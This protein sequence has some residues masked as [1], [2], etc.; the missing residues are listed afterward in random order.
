[1]MKQIKYIIVMLFANLTMAQQ[2]TTAKLS[3]VHIDGLHEI[4]LPNEIRSFSKRNLNDFR[5]LDSYGKEVPFFIRKKNKTTTTN[6]FI[7]FE[8]ISRTVAKDTSSII[9]FKNPYSTLQNMVITVANF[10]GSKTYSL[11]G[12][13]DQKQWFGLVNNNRLSN[14]QDA[15]K[16]SIDKAISF[17]LSSYPY[18]RIVF[19]DKNSQALNVLKIGAISS[20]VVHQDLQEVKIKSKIITEIPDLKKT[21]IHITFENYEI[22]NH[23]LFQIASPELYNRQVRFYKISLRE[24]KH[25]TEQYQENLARFNLNSS[26]NKLFNISEIFENDIYI[27]IDNKDDANLTFNEIEFFQEPLYIIA[28]LKAKENYI[29]KTGD[30]NLD[31]PQYDISYFKNNIADHLPKAE[32]INVVQ[33]QQLSN[34]IDDESFWQKSWFMWLSILLAGI[35][36]LYFT[37]SLVKDIKKD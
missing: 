27:E 18:L 16:T 26:N 3:E 31:A 30:E 5:I 21:Q 12:S 17:P 2:N 36:I 24:V 4:N 29:V 33:E 19:N 1:M 10:A 20:Q 8:I 11:S 7:K 37:M 13:N 32:I 6:D 25:K 28:S 9:T 34:D 15:K 23:I 35:A 14:L 22:I